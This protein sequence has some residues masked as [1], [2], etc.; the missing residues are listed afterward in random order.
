M[1]C[2]DVDQNVSKVRL[3]LSNCLMICVI[4]YSERCMNRNLLTH[5]HTHIWARRRARWLQRHIIKAEEGILN[6]L[7]SL[8]FP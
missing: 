8:K 3:E 5:T 2:S 6:M 1:T 7:K 4:G